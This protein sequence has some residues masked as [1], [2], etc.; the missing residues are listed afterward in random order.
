MDLEYWS[1]LAS[2]ILA[3]SPDLVSVADARSTRIAYMN[4]SGRDL[5]GCSLEADVCEWQISDFVPEDQQQWMRAEVIPAVLRDG[6]WSGEL[7]LRDRLGRSVPVLSVLQVHRDDQAQVRYISMISKSIEAPLKREW[8]LE[9]TKSELEDFYDHAPCAYYGIN[10]NGVLVRIND[11]A[12]KWF[13]YQREEVVGKMHISELIPSEGASSFQACFAKVAAGESL[14]NFEVVMKRKD[15]S[16]V[17]GLLN[18]SSTLDSE[19]NFKQC[20]AIIA[21][22][23]N[24]KQLE[25]EKELAKQQLQHAA[26]LTTL[27][28]MAAG[29][30]HEINQ[31]LAHLGVALQLMRRALQSGGSA[32]GHLLPILAEMESSINRADRVIRHA[33]AFG[34]KQDFELHA[35]D[36]NQTLCAALDLM[37]KALKRDAIDLG[38]ELNPELPPIL[39]NPHQLEQVWINL[40]SNARDALLDRDA[41]T[42]TAPT[43]QRPKLLVVR[44]RKA[45][46]AI[47]IDIEDQGTGMSAQTLEKIFQPFYTTKPP[48]RG[49]GLG[50]SIS[51]SVIRDLG[52]TIAVRSELGRGT[53]FTISLPSKEVQS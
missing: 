49:T 17:F 3:G 44:T 27:G 35:M 10:S 40:I 50:L 5:T 2:E 30:A 9:I 45:D 41:D 31:P 4:E 43:Q 37:S 51:F 33:Q 22:I 12:L 20:R 7:T 36:V 19:G 29:M 21:D 53:C 25:T 16:K 34:R 8:D 26:R 46:S 1:Q 14:K 11:A 38:V 15:G 42:S 23:T 48:G 6:K 28:E 32:E 13:G 24:L 47:E 39:G 52:G 18:S